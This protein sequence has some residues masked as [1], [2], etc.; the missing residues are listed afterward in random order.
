MKGFFDFLKSQGV[1]GLAV[2]FILGAALTKMVT[3]LVNDV[4]N[5]VLGPILGAAKELRQ[6]S[7]QIGPVVLPWGDFVAT[8]IDFLII[9]LVV[10][11]L[12]KGLGMEKAEPKPK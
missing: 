2:A 11:L 12:V 3:A 1:I 10:Y 5:P 8:T 4:I 9:A 7:V 6:V